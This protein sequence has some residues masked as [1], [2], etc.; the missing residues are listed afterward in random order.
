MLTSNLSELPETAAGFSATGVFL[1][2]LKDFSERLLLNIVHSFRLGQVLAG[3]RVIFCL[4]SL[5]I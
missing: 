1:E 2:I 4:I 3:N 5:L